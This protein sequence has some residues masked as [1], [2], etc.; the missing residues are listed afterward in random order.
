MRHNKF[1][2]WERFLEVVE[3]VEKVSP[4]LSRQISKRASE[5]PFW[6]SGVHIEEWSDEQ[7]WVRLPI[8]FRNTVDGEICHGHLMLASELALRLLL[9]RFRQEFPFRYRLRIGKVETH[10]RVDQSVDFKFALLAAERERL[11][12][13]LARN[14]SSETDFVIAAT[15]N[16]GRLAATLTWQVAFDL[17]KFL[18]A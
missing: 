7:V 10:H 8:S 4:W 11:R 13:E 5:W 2:G 15:L 1:L 16:D 12:L 17:E 18:P 9:L 14:T 6:F 3:R